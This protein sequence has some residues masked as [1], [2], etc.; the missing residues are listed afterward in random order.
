M[1]P[2]RTSAR[3]CT[4]PASAEA[5]R[6]ARIP[7]GS[8]ARRLVIEFFRNLMRKTLEILALVAFA[9]L[10]WLTWAA[11]YGPSRLPD[12][13]P[14]HFNAAGQADAWGAPAGMILLPA[15]A[16]ALYLL[17]S[18]V[19]RFPG[20][21][22]YPVRATRLNIIRLESIALAMIAWLKLE[23]MCLFALLQWAFIQAA[24]SGSGRIFPM[25]LP[26]FIV[27]IFGTIGWCF[28]AMFRA[29]PSPPVSRP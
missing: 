24:R 13:V 17:M 12:R 3:P 7:Y 2:A 5:P 8:R 29:A 25:I 27:A 4:A 14:T 18:I 11:L 28:V 21:F 19:A 26:L 10:C 1:S 16:A 15:V 23:L 20:A 9:V 6:A 22:H